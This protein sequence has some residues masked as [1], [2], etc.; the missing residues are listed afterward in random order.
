LLAPLLVSFLLAVAVAAIWATAAAMR[1]MSLS[2]ALRMGE[3]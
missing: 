2:R 1:R 3:R